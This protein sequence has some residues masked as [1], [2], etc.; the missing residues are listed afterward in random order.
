MN[1]TKKSGIKSMRTIL[2]TI[3]GTAT[4]KLELVQI[5]TVQNSVAKYRYYHKSADSTVH[6]LSL[7]RE[8]IDFLE[9]PVWYLSAVPILSEFFEKTLSALY[10]SGSTRTR[11]RCPDFRC[12]CLPTLG[13][14]SELLLL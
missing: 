13:Y 5:T 8:C 7:S 6:V 11:Q 3:S 14:D 9:N 4:E 2:S 1:L 12:P 10:L